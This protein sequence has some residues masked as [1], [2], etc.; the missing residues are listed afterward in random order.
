[1]HEYREL[2]YASYRTGHYE[3]INP[4]GLNRS[5][6]ED[7]RSELAD[8][9]PLD[10]KAR[11]VDLGCGKGFL[12]QFLLRE[13]YENVLGVDTSEEQVE[14]G[15][16]LGLPVVHADALDFLRGNKNLDLVIST[17]VIEHFGKDE[18]VDLLRAIYGALAPGGSVI[19]RTI[20]CS[21][22][23]GSTARYTDFTHETGFTERSLRQV[24]MACG[25]KR[26]LITDSKVPFRWKPKR[27]VRW[28]LFKLWRIVLRIILA[29]EAGGASPR[30][31]GADLIAQA[32]KPSNSELQEGVAS[33]TRPR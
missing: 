31:L 25:F 19:I 11:V 23:L 10:R 28:S 13:G 9:L 5:H 2:L 29:L 17:D 14:F 6:I 27:V 12:V 1:M 7:F 32:F 21:S 15:K 18:I 24:L 22:I 3:A 16:N 8:F 30:L 4:G 33:P 20:N 26:V